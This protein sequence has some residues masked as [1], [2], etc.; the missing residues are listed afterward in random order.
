[1]I[2]VCL[3]VVKWWIMWELMYLVLLIMRI[4][5]DLVWIKRVVVCVFELDNVCGGGKD[6]SL[7][8]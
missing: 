4:F 8:C 3:D 6:C 7:F 5:M 1:M 2:G